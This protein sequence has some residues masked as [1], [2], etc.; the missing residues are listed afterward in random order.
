MPRKKTSGSQPPRDTESYSV[1]YKKTKLKRLYEIAKKTRLRPGTY[2]R[3]LLDELLERYDECG[4]VPWP[5]A[6]VSR[7]AAIEAGIIPPDAPDLESN[8]ESPEEYEE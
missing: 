5:L 1:R 8:Q 6:V 2:L 7:K 4:E 3:I